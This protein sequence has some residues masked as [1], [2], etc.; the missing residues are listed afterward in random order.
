MNG[1]LTGNPEVTFRDFGQ[2]LDQTITGKAGV[3]DRTRATVVAWSCRTPSRSG[4]AVRVSAR[5]VTQPDPALPPGGERRAAACELLVTRYHWLVRSCVR[6]YLNS[7][8][9]AEDLMQ[10]GY[11]GLLKAIGNFAPAICGSLAAYARGGR[12][13]SGG[14]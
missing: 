9:P 8:E 4:P 5:A 13:T 11:V 3:A 6:L 14:L 12:S 1:A 7:P 2:P 10:V